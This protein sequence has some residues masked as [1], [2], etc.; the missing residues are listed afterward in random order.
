MTPDETDLTAE[1]MDAI[2][3]DAED[4]L[5]VSARTHTCHGG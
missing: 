3:V 2:M 5:L 1:E 4:V